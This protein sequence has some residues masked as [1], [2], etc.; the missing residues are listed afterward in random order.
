M[1]KTSTNSHL[2]SNGENRSESKERNNTAD[3]GLKA[4]SALTSHREVQPKKQIIITKKQRYCAADLFRQ[5]G[6]PVPGW[7]RTSF[8]INQRRRKLLNYWLW[9]ANVGKEYCGQCQ[10]SDDLFCHLHCF[11]HCINGVPPCL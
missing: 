3:N 5:Y 6:K 1:V 10:S 8:R 7:L 11:W 2:E 4:K 9:E